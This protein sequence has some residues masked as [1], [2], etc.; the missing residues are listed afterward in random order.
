MSTKRIFN[1]N[2]GP[3]ILPLEVLEEIKENFMNFG[4]M[5]ILEISHRSKA[6]EAIIESAKE[7]LRALMQIPKN[8]QILFLQGGAS[9]Q[10][11]MV[12]L[13]LLDK[14]ADYAITGYWAKKA[15]AEAKLVGKTNVVFSS[16]EKKF[17][18]VP[19]PSEIKTTANTSYLHITSNNTIYGTEY[20]AFPETGA[21]P[22]VADMSSD[23]L[24]RK[25][26]VSKFGLIYAGAQK[27]IGPAGVTVV[28]IRD[29]LATKNYH[30]V[31][32]MLKYST[33]TEN[34][35]LFNTPPVFAIYAMKLTLDWLKKQGLEKIES[36]NRQK[37]A[38]LYE[39][40]DG[41]S[42][43]KGSADKDSRSLMNV[44][45]NLPTPELE[46]KFIKEAAAKDMSGLKGHRLVGGIRASIYN[47][48]PLDG[49]KE[50]FAFMK[51]F[52]RKQ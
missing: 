18:R 10:F 38:M 7:N 2:A 50:L 49:V 47:A 6:F 17:S 27:N 31:H 40:I 1:F 16:E 5:S 20:H 33:H 25:I 52:E 15:A 37:A 36:L 4:G 11:A 8:Y 26:D 28:L 24:C 21:V 23:I 12:P 9:L 32:T 13:N 51:E 30:S 43:Y 46:E 19:T 3:S 35:S 44:T 29:D 14:E 45:F 48:F 34:N 39:A 42:F 41:S 22:L